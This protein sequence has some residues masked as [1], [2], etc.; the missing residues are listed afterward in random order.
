[1]LQDSPSFLHVG[2]SA[3]YERC[4]K[5]A[6]EMKWLSRVPERLKEAKKWLTVPDESFLW[7]ELPNGYRMTSLSDACYGDVEQ[8]W[9]LI[10]SEQAA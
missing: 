2:D 1:M 6:V 9:I 10:H 7:T 3:M 8:R 5:E 4:V